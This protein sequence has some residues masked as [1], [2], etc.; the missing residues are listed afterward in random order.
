MKCLK[1]I[2]SDCIASKMSECSEKRG[3]S[4]QLK[5]SSTKYMEEAMGNDIL[6]KELLDSKDK[7]SQSEPSLIY[8]NTNE[9]QSSSTGSSTSTTTVNISVFIKLVLIFTLFLLS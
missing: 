2:L 3:N 1:N 4:L 6:T 5:T 8:Y 9:P 7:Y